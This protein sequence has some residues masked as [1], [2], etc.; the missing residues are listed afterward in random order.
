MFWRTVL[1]VHLVIAA[2][3]AV[4]LDRVAIIVGRRVVKTS[5]LDRD[6]RASQFV[7][8]E[9]LNLSPEAKRKITERLI[10]QELIR[11]EVMGG[12]YS[13]PAEQEAV[14]F[15]Q[16]LKRDRA[17]GSDAQFAAALAKYGLTEEQLRQYLWWQL[18][19]LRFIEERFRPG[20]LVTDE[21]VKAYYE[22]NRAQLEK[23][24]PKSNSFE[25]LD[26]K[27]RDIL[28]GERVNKVFNEWLDQARRNT[29]IQTRE[30]A[31]AAETSTGVSK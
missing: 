31:F 14:E 11:Q 4:V 28:V 19:V 29:R 1:C 13:R 15:L 12:G 3:G 16:Q 21:D 18:T 8:R 27:I 17:A 26:P 9:S 10:D 7:N 23:A 24:Y 6:L 30:A 22:Q 25:A 20:V 5:D 2:Y